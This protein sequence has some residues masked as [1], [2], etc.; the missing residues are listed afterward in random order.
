M[1]DR[2][3]D[4]LG[5][6]LFFIWI[7]IC[8]LAGLSFMVLL[9]GAGIIIVCVQLARKFSNLKFEVFWFIV[10]LLGIIGGLWKLLNIEFDLI[11]ILMII[12]GVLLLISALTGKKSKEATS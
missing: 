7:G 12:A 8:Y 10:G 4:A 1:T 6:G 5:W 2:N 9:L 11:P 3:Y